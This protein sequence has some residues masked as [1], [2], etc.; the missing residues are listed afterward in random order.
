MR[1]A[2]HLVLAVCCSSMLIQRWTVSRAGSAPCSIVA[3]G[4]SITWGAYAS[5]NTVPSLDT[6]IEP[7]SDHLVGPEDT[8]YPGDLSRLI[9]RAVCNYGVSGELAVAGAAR[10]RSLLHVFRPRSV[11]LM[12]GVNDLGAG[13]SVTS[14]LG[15]LETMLGSARRAGVLPVLLTLTPT[16]YPRESS[17]YHVNAD[18]GAVNRGIRR[19][20]AHLH[21]PVADVERAFRRD[22]RGVELTRHETGPDYLH[23]NDAGYLLIARAVAPALAHPSRRAALPGS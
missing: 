6:S 9:H 2:L 13:E 1:R 4:D 11:L 3:L 22:G 15:A 19:L 17:H 20:G 16:Y 23:P 7:V 10:L 21:V 12:E 18:V 5:H 8:K 14:V